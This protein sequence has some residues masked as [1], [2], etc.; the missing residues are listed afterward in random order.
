MAGDGTTT[1]EPVKTVV[2]TLRTADEPECTRALSVGGS[3]KVGTMDAKQV[4]VGVD[5]SDQSLEALAYASAEAAR[6]GGS[7]RVVA[8]FESTGM[9]GD[10]YGLP[11]PVSD[12]TIADRLTEDTTALVK[13]ALE[14]LAEPPPTQVVVEVGRASAVLVAESE[15]ADLLVV[16]HRGHGGVT[17]AVLGSVALHCVSHARCPV[18]V[19]RRAG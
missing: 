14:S 4:V 9:F 2:P 10:R 5:G 1:C 13:K 12:Q 6:W 18:T 15:R 7:L 8:A 19:V 16:G 11:I 3:R 17:G